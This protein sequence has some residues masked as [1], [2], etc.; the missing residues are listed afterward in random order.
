MSLPGLRLV[1]VQKKLVERLNKAGK[2]GM[3]NNALFDYLYSHDENGG[4]EMGN[5][6]LSSTIAAINKKLK[7]LNKKIVNPHRGRAT[8]AYYRI[9]DL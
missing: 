4:P 6:A 7:P 1:G 8:S 3:E 9:V 2:N 5:N